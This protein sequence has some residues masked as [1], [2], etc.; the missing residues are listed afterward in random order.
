MFQDVPGCASAS[1]T[2]VTGD[3]DHV[4]SGNAVVTHSLFT[5]DLRVLRCALMHTLEEDH[6]LHVEIQKEL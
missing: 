2:L 5:C 1:Q 6:A 4:D 3:T